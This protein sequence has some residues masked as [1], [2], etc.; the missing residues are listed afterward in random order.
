VGQTLVA[1]GQPFSMY[2]PAKTAATWFPE[3][4]RALANTLG[5]VGEFASFILK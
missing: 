4:Q 5:A 3:N 1:L 2:A